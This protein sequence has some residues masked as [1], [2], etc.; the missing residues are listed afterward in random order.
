MDIGF[1]GL[2]KGSNFLKIS[3]FRLT[4]LA[5]TFAV[6]LGAVFLGAVFFRLAALVVAF[7]DFAAVFFFVPVPAFGLVFFLSV[8]LIKLF[9]PIRAPLKLKALVASV[10][11]YN[12]QIHI[13][14]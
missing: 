11:I 5:E 9:L 4:F 6:L 8:D 7:E 14:D 10:H 1:L 2:V 13:K 3:F 12:V